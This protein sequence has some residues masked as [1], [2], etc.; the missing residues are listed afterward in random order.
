MRMR[1][2]RRTHWS[3]VTRLRRRLAGLDREHADLRDRLTL[4]EAAV[5]G[6]EQH[7][8][9][10]AV[11]AELLRPRPSGHRFRRIG[12]PGDGG[13]VVADLGPPALVVSVGVGDECS[14]DDELA[15]QGAAVWQFDHTVPSSPTTQPGVTFVP[16]GVCGTDA[17]PSCAPLATLIATVDGWRDPAWLLMDV[18][19]AEWD[20]LEDPAAGWDRFV[21][22]TIELH[23]LAQVAASPAW[24]RGAR[25]LGAITRD[26]VPVA[27]HANDCSPTRVVGGRW[28][29]EV[30]EISLVRRDRWCPGEGLPPASLFHPNDPQRLEQGPAPFARVTSPAG[31]LAPSWV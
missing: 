14:A 24:S 19:G 30:L 13:Y 2:A 8:E 31:Q 22:V 29:P 21:Q 25:A 16:T 26:H 17:R 9:A 23:G 27:W 7:R 4:L 12:R 1:G 3:P 10:V 6:S 5:T 18:E 11:M 28:V 20:V 15:A